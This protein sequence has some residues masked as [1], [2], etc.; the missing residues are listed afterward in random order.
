MSQSG[1]TDSASP[2]RADERDG[3]L[4][5]PQSHVGFCAILGLPNAGKSTLLNRMLGRRLTAVSR[6][7]QTTR[8]RIL[9]VLNRTVETDDRTDDRTDDTSAASDDRAAPNRSAQIVF[10][11]TPG[12]QVGKGALRNYMRTQS[13]GAA[14]DSD[15]ALLLVDV[16][17]PGQRDPERFSAPDTEE[18]WGALQRGQAPVYLALNKVDT[19]RDK[20][21]LLPILDAYSD[22]GVFD[23]LIPISAK[24]GRGVAGLIRAIARRLPL[25]HKYFPEDMVT[26]RAERF[27]AAELIREQLFRQLGQELPYT[28][29]VIVESMREFPGRD[30]VS[31][32][33]VIYVERDS[34]TGIVVGKGGRRVKELGQR[35]RAAIAELFGCPVHL[36]LRVKVASNWSR[37]EQGI[38]RMGYE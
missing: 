31:L 23:E 16:G 3:D 2:E 36:T 4:A 12:I 28:T 24:T 33:A 34:Q 17:D 35:G 26:D 27:L 25:G 14:G 29:A 32:R 18:L 5:E 1:T 19:L 7:P 8:N 22:T 13:L 37:V 10:M 9:G 20:A 6:K 38:R 15:I 21:A 30:D 11:D